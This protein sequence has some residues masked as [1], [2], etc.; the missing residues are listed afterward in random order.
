M[1]FQGPIYTDVGKALHNRLIGTGTLKFTKMQMGDGS[2]GGTTIAALTALINPLVTMEVRQVKQYSDYIVVTA[3]FTNAT[4]TTAF[5]W[6]EI[7]LFAADPDY[8]NDRTKDILFCYQNAYSSA[9]SIPPGSQEFIERLVNIPIKL[10]DV[11]DV[12]ITISTSLIYALKNPATGKI[13]PEDIPDLNYISMAQKGAANGVAT[14]GEDGK[15]TPSQVDYLLK[16]IVA[17][18][19]YDP[20]TTYAAGAYRTHGGK[21]YKCT[22]PITSAETWNAAHWTETSV[23]A[24]IAALYTALAGKADI[25]KAMYRRDMTAAQLNSCAPYSYTAI[26][27]VV[28]DFG[29][30]SDYWIVEYQFFDVANGIQTI[31]AA[32]TG[33][34]WYRVFNGGVAGAWVSSFRVISQYN[35]D[36]NTFTKPGLYQIQYNNSSGS[37]GCPN[38]P[39][40]DTAYSHFFIQVYQHADTF[41][42][43]VAYEVNT[44]GMYTRNSID[45]VWQPWQKVAITKYLPA[46]VPVNWTASGGYYYQDISVPGVLAV[47]SP[48][49]DFIPSEDNAANEL[50]AEAWGKILHITTYDGHIRIWCKTAPTVAYNMQLRVVK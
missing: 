48:I 21:L 9:A 15:V 23:G 44:N 42:V 32:V 17:A 49:T 29:P 35:A 27:G 16:S 40:G 7:G 36:F 18:A 47:E 14:L 20:A 10:S 13:Y 38:S 6:R 41:V 31:T 5:N 26:T 25:S 4:I 3:P 24:E 11:S 28:A 50:Y 33:D 46:L 43:Q 22:T 12:T 2:L 45:G 1:S 8:P 37:G 39:H 19:D 34:R 30:R